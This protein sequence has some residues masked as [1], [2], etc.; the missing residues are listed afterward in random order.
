MLL[1]FCFVL[2]LLSGAARL[3]AQPAGATMPQMVGVGVLPDQGYSWEKIRTATRG[4][5]SRR[6]LLAN[7]FW[8]KKG[9]FRRCLNRF[10]L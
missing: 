5:C 6:I 8:S 4:S 9:Y 1:R 3:A 10:C 7:W 2:L